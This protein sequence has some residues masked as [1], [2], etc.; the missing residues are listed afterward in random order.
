MKHAKIILDKTLELLTMI[1]VGVLVID[2][3][4]QIFTRFVLNNPSSWTEEFST[5]LLMWVG[6]LGAAV[7]VNRT[8]HL[9]VD[10]LVLK[11]PPRLRITVELIVYLLVGTF[12][13][14]VMIV[15]GIELVQK[16]LVTNQTSP[17][18]NWKMGYVY[19]CLPVSGFFITVYSALFMG[20]ALLKLMKRGSAGA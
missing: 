13:V 9:G 3:V 15:G 17:A 10:Y 18:L 7:A 14:T 12:A 19:L 16:T 11:F 4:W 8:A 20:T 5:F 1:A 2:V 6:L